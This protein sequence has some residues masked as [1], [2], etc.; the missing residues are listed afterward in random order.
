MPQMPCPGKFFVDAT[1]TIAE[2]SF[3]GVLE[4][5]SIA[6][7]ANNTMQPISDSCT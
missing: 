7:T 2:T 5:L 3:D 6:L 1:S 4:R